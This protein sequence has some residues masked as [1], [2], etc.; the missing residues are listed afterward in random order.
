M[1]FLTPREGV[2]YCS[3][4]AVTSDVNVFRFHVICL[5]PD[6]G[7]LQ[8]TQASRLYHYVPSV[9]D[10]GVDGPESRLVSHEVDVGGS[11]PA[12]G[13]GVVVP[14]SA[15]AALQQHA[16]RA[17]MVLNLQRQVHTSLTH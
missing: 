10:G 1:S 11:S 7:I 13:E 14:R 17:E 5:T 4:T 12:V 2:N 9:R 16:A 8:R 3:M 6:L 15:Q